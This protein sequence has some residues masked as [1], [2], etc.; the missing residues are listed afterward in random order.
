[1]NLF[2]VY[3]NEENKTIENLFLRYTANEEIRRDDYSYMWLSD[4]QHSPL[5]NLTITIND[6]SKYKFRTIIY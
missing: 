4:T 5:T 3:M 2:N 6:D 1:M